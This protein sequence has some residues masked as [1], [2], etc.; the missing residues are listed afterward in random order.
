MLTPADGPWCAAN[1]SRSSCGS[2]PRATP[3]T[4]CASTASRPCERCP[5]HRC[6]FIY[7][8]HT[9]CVIY[10]APVA[11]MASRPASAPHT[12]RPCSTRLPAERA[13]KATWLITFLFSCV[14][15]K[16]REKNGAAARAVAGA[17]RAPPGAASRAR[18]LK[19]NLPAA[20]R[21]CRHTFS[22]RCIEQG[23]HCTHLFLRLRCFLF[24]LSLP[25]SSLPMMRPI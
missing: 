24:P 7:P 4:T 12:L 23:T 5:R 25:G 6:H 9:P 8:V 20:C 19:R 2:W 1:L 16:K 11:W 10:G 18:H 22:A 3:T 15:E 13:W 14:A 17:Q 21:R